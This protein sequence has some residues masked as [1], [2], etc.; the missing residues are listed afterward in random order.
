MSDQ[1][2]YYESNGAQA[3]PISWDGL[4]VGIKMGKVTHET[5]VWSSHLTEWTSL[6]DCIQKQSTAILPPSADF[7]PSQPNKNRFTPL[8]LITSAVGILILLS[9]VVPAVLHQREKAEDKAFELRIDHAVKVV[10]KSLETLEANNPTMK[11]QY[12]VM[13]LFKAEPDPYVRSIALI[14]YKDLGANSGEKIAPLYFWWSSA[15]AK[16]LPESHLKLTLTKLI[17]QDAISDRSPFTK[18]YIAQCQNWINT[19]E[20]I[21]EKEVGKD[22]LLGGAIWGQTFTDFLATYPS[23]NPSSPY[24]K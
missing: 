12:L 13:E 16:S 10:S 1:Q 23:N 3:G 5:R 20:K 9:V 22:N 24:S 6:G 2:W 15:F 4:M 11:P 14:Q 18:E 17:A 21:I 8:R 19:P 7:H